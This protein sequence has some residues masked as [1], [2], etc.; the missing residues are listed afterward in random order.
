EP[1]A[2]VES[3]GRH[4]TGPTGV[5]VTRRRPVRRQ[6]R[7]TQWNQPSKWLVEFNQNVGDETYR[8]PIGNIRYLNRK[9]WGKLVSDAQ[10][11]S[12]QRQVF[13]LVVQLKIGVQLR[14]G[15]RPVFA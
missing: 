7:R 13:A 3:E 4:P 11:R 2:R 6:R 5:N 9:R 8:H 15:P 1:R 14:V 10:V 12:N